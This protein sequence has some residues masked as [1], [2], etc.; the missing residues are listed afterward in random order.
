MAYRNPLQVRYN[1]NTSSGPKT[2]IQDKHSLTDLTFPELLYGF[3]HVSFAT[4]KREGFV[5]ASVKGYHS[6]HPRP[7]VSVYEADWKPLSP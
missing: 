2:F 1:F 6:A 4:A 7:G 5:R 3:N